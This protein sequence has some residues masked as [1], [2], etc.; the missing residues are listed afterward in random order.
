MQRSAFLA[1][2][3]TG[4]DRGRPKKGPPDA[5]MGGSVNF[6][7]CRGRSPATPDITGQDS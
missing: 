5:A 1:L 7:R 3:L 2:P 6:R 4:K